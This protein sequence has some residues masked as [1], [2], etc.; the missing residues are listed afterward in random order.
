MR[1]KVTYTVDSEEVLDEVTRL[2]NSKLI[3]MKPM[4]DIVAAYNFGDRPIKES[5]ELIDQL[6][7]KLYDLDTTLLDVDG[8]LKSYASANL[9]PKE[10]SGE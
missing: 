7:K 10:N 9:M 5:L 4:I 8:I 1:V 6:R 2:V 3:P